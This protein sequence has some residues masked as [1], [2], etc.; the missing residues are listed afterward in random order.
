MVARFTLDEHNNKIP[1]AEALKRKAAEGDLREQIKDLKD[2]IK[3]EKQEIHAVRDTILECG[4]LLEAGKS[5]SYTACSLLKAA[6]FERGELSGKVSSAVE[7]VG[8]ESMKQAP[9]VNEPGRPNPP[10]NKQPDK[11]DKTGRRP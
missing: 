10:K 11:R 3:V 5:I 2:Q 1:L 8:A 7:T 9:D 4:L 6:Y